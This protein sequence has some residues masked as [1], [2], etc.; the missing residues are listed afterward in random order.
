MDA[1][2]S[3]SI[4]SADLLNLEQALQECESAGADKIHI[5]VMFHLQFF[6]RTCSTWGR[7][8]ESAK[9]RERIRFISM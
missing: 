4:L 3:P 1:L 6:L 7:H 8:C 9:V 2:I 5:D